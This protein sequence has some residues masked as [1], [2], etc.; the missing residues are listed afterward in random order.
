MNKL[1]KEAKNVYWTTKKAIQDTKEKKS[2]E[3]GYPID[4]TR[5]AIVVLKNIKNVSK[6]K[7]NDTLVQ[8]YYLRLFNQYLEQREEMSPKETRVNQDRIPYW[9]VYGR[10]IRR[11]R[12]YC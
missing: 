7:Y 1:T 9:K 3:E 10:N 12:I 11:P 8:Y 4:P 5:I 2:L 6:R